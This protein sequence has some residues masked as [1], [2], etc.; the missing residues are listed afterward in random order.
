MAR[1][2][3]EEK[4]VKAQSAK[5]AKKTAKASAKTGK[6]RTRASSKKETKAKAK[7]NGK[8]VSSPFMDLFK[9][10]VEAG[11]VTWAH[12]ARETGMSRSTLY[13]YM[14]KGTAPKDW[15]RAKAMAKAA[16]IPIKA[17]KEAWK[18]TVSA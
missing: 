15:E 12:I 16:G 4:E 1:K 9:A 7:G 14:R 8:A 10:Q 5:S 6:T 3:K 17:A 13:A 18:A 2:K 11:K